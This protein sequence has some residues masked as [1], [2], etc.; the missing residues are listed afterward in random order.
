MMNQKMDMNTIREINSRLFFGSGSAEKSEETRPW[1]YVQ[2]EYNQMGLTAPS[3]VPELET[4]ED[5]DIW[6]CL[7][8][9][10]NHAVRMRENAQLLA[11]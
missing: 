6:M 1:Q 3:Y 4:M 2:M 10:V 7:D 11:G 9:R 5:A 8:A